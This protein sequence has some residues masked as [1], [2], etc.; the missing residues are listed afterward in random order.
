MQ[1]IKP[2]SEER[3]DGWENRMAFART[4]VRIIAAIIQCLITYLLLK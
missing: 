1:E 3:L 4:I 2:S